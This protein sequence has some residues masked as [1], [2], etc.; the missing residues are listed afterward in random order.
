[1]AIS[2]LFLIRQW[3][4]N[5]HRLSVAGEMSNK[6]P[7]PQGPLALSSLLSNSSIAHLRIQGK[8]IWRMKAI[9]CWVTETIRM[10]SKVS[11]PNHPCPEPSSP[12]P[13][14]LYLGF[15]FSSGAQSCLTLCD[16]M[17]RSTPGLPVHHQ[18]PEFTQTPVHRVSDAI[19]PSHPLS[20]PSPPA[21]NTS[22][23]QS[24]FQWV[25]SSHEVAKVLEFQL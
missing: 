17:N 16:P 2:F 18:H 9:L 20:S 12:L 25:N 10:L 11:S 15:Q 8:E 7:L 4:S 19:Q 5:C 6:G 1:M 13:L 24:F 21:P 22:Q 3:S 23:H 14:A